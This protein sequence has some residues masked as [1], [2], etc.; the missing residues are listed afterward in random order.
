MAARGTVGFSTESARN[1][2]RS[3]FAPDIAA[4]VEFNMLRVSRIAIWHH[5]GTPAEPGKNTEHLRNCQPKPNSARQTSAFQNFSRSLERPPHRPRARSQPRSLRHH[6]RHE[7]AEIRELEKRSRE[8]G[9]DAAWSQ[10]PPLNVVRSPD[11]DWNAL[12]QAVRLHRA[13][14]SPKEPRPAKFTRLPNYG[15]G[16]PRLHVSTAPK[17][18]SIFPMNLHEK[19]Y[20]LTEQL[21]YYLW[22]QRGSPSGSPELDWEVAEQTLGEFLDSFRRRAWDSGIALGPDTSSAFPL[23]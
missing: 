16:S 5:S 20:Q 15:K 14:I 8:P 18:A 22:E 2:G 6:L 3:F 21:A 10:P 17:P 11:P 1:F 13:N 4:I 9:L 19:V 7:F 23:E 12:A